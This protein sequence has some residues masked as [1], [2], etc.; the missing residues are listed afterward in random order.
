LVLFFRVLA[1]LPSSSGLSSRHPP[2]GACD[3]RRR[4]VDAR[5]RAGDNGYAA[6][7]EQQRAAILLREE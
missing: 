2:G 4:R 5:G 7:V 3:T 6:D 1:P